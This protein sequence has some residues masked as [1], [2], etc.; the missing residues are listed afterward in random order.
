MGRY[1]IS[2][3]S[4]DTAATADHVGAQLWN[5][6]SA[7]SVYVIEVAY[8]MVGA[9]A[10]FPAL[11]RSSARGSTPT[12]TATP[13]EDNDFDALVTPAS[14]TVLE[15]ATF[16]SQ[17][18]I[19]GPYMYRQNVPAAAGAGVIWNFADKPIRVPAGTGLVVATPVST[20]LQDGDFT[21]VFDD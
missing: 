19:D 13:D 15:L 5:P 14:A 2:G 6:A 8:T 21:F 7:R 11:V 9:T 16:S 10:C 17:P 12:A 18:T 20:I 4:L 3:R 1:A